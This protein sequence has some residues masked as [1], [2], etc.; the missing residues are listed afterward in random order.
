MK[1]SVVR[2]SQGGK[3]TKAEEQIK[4]LI[5]EDLDIKIEP[6]K[7]YA[8]FKIIQKLYHNENEE[9]KI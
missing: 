4:K 3:L 6:M 2:G 8:N 5:E 1:E 7:D 9:K